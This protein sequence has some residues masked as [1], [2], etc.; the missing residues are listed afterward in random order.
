MHDRIAPGTVQSGRTL[1]D[2]P[3]ERD[4]LAMARDTLKQCEAEREDDDRRDDL[5]PGVRQMRARA[6]AE[7]K[8]QAH[9]ILH[10]LP[11]DPC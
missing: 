8:R 7:R 10:G 9:R 1:N 6:R 5:T 2:L 3:R 11:L 4:L